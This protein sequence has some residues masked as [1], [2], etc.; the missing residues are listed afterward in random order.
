M[1]LNKN[2]SCFRLLC[3]PHI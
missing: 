2:C 1:P 3:C